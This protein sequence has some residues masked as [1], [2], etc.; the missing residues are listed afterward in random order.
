[1]VR[2]QR[3]G[4]TGAPRAWLISGSKVQPENRSI[5]LEIIIRVLFHSIMIVLSLYLLFAGHNLPGGGFAGGLVAGMG[6]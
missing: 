3:V 2:A 1:M 6:L 5:L 4:E